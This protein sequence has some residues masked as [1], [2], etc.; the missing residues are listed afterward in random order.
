[1]AVLGV[2]LTPSTLNERLQEHGPT[3]YIGLVLF[4]GIHACILSILFKNSNTFYQ[5]RTQHNW[6]FIISTQLYF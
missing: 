4:D 6:K 1:M 2:L 5:K 3:F